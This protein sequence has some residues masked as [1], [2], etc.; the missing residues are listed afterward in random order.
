MKRTLLFIHSAG[1]QDE[2]EGSD[3]LIAYLKEQL[4]SHYE[5]VHPFMPDPENPRYSTWKKQ[6]QE[7]MA[8]IEGHLL[9][10]GH[11]LGGSVLLK[12]LAETAIDKPIDALFLIATPFWGKKHWEIEEF[13]LPPTFPLQLPPIGRLFLYHSRED[14]WV[15]FTHLVHYSKLLPRATVRSLEGHEHEFK[16]GLPELVADI[17]SIDHGRSI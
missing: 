4:G 16:K 15:P 11:S 17:K 2:R 12:Y 6:L 10:V 9:L 5:L 1:K 13:E 8:T 7:A 3:R 14:E